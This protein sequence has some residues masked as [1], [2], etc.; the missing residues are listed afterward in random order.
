MCHVFHALDLESGRIPDRGDGQVFDAERP[1]A[2][3]AMEMDVTVAVLLFFR[4]MADLIP[5]AVPVG[6][7]MQ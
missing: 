7:R 3:L 5:Y 6:K 1:S 2:Q 4:T